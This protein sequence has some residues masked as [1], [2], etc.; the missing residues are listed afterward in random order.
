VRTTFLESE[1]GVGGAVYL[2]REEIA[3]RVT[4]L[5]VEIASDYEGLDLLL[6]A[7]VG[8]SVVFFRNLTRALLTPHMVGLVE[9]GH[10]AANPAADTESVRLL[11]DV[12]LPIADRHVLVVEAVVDTGLTLHFLSKTLNQWKPASLAAVTLLDRPYRRLVEELPLRYVGFTVAD[13]LF[14][15]YGFGPEARWR[16]RPDLHLFTPSKIRT[17]NRAVDDERAA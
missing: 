15:G 5:G 2:R 14:A 6:V 1:H 3:A 13:E 7:S 9:L 12:D 16:A 11:R 8:S 17:W 4:E 10:C